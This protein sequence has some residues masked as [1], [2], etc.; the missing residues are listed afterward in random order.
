M[1]VKTEY[2]DGEAGQAIAATV[3][4]VEKSVVGTTF[5]NAQGNAARVISSSGIKSAG[6]APD[7]VTGDVVITASLSAKPPTEI[8]KS[9]PELG[10]LTQ[11]AE[12]PKWLAQV[13]AVASSIPIVVC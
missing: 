6:I 1:A 13:I 2:C 12:P 8:E 10:S 4:D 5:P 11:S 7:P 9:A 3:K